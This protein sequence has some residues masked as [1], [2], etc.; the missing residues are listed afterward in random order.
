M[1][2]GKPGKNGQSI[3]NRSTKLQSTGQQVIGGSV[4]QP[5][6][7]SKRM[8]QSGKNSTLG[9]DQ[10]TNKALNKRLNVS[11]VNEGTA[12]KTLDA[13]LKSMPT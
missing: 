3:N 8:M 12:S 10:A 11:K 13:A 6:D 4:A 2:G 9:F 7:A 5:G 1:R